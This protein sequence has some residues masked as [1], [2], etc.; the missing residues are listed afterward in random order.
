MKRICKVN[1]IFLLA[2]CLTAALFVNSCSVR[3][4]VPIEGPLALK[5]SSVVK[6]QILFMANCQKCHPVGEPG[7]GLSLNSNPAPGFLKR[8][9]VRH[10]LGVMPSFSK[11]EVTGEELD[12]IIS[13]MTARRRNN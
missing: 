7:L 4:S 1:L 8:F 2:S 10:G 5:D 12:D 6:G 11:K 3:R 9:Q 13:Y